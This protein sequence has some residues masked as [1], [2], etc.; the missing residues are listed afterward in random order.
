MAIQTIPGSAITAGTI[1][2]TQMS[3]T[4]QMGGPKISSIILTDSGYATITD[5]ALG[6]SGG[7][8]RILGTG[9]VTGCSVSINTV[10][11]TSV[12]FISS[13]EVRAQLP[14]MSAGTY[15]MYLSNSDGGV[16]IRVNAL[17]YSSTPS[18]TSTSPLTGGVVNTAISIQLG[19]TSD[20]TIS[21]TVQ[22]GSTLPTGLTLSSGG[23]LAGTVTGIALETTYNFTVVATDLESQISPKAFS[24]TIIVNDQYFKSTVLL[25]N[26]DVTPFTADAS[27]NKFE[28]SAVGTPSANVNNPLQPGYYSGSFNGSADYLTVPYGVWSAAATSWTIEGWFNFN[29]TSGTQGLF[30][31][32]AAF[33]VFYTGSSITISY[34]HTPSSP[35][36]ADNISAYTFTVRQWYHI[37]IVLTSGSL[38]VYV[39]GI[40]IGSPTTGIGT[41]AYW[42]GLS[43]AN[44]IMCIGANDTYPFGG[45]DTFFNGYISNVRLTNTAVYTGNFTPPTLSLTSTQSAGFLAATATPTVDILVVAGGGSGGGGGNQA[46][47]GGGGAGGVTPINSLSLSTGVSY[48]VTVGAGA[49]AVAEGSGTKGGNSAFGTTT[50]EGGGFGGGWSYVSSSGGSGGGAGYG[51][52]QTASVSNAVAPQLGNSGGDGISAGGYPGG[53]GGAGAAGGAALNSSTGGN[54][55]AGY[56][57]SISGVSTYYGGG[58]GAGVWTGTRGV[59]G[60]GGGGNGS[61]SA[62][63]DAALSNTGGGGGGSTANTARG[64]GGSG[65][66]GIVVLRYSS[67]YSLPSS[68]TGN[69]SVV[70][71]GGYRI[72]TWTTSGT[73]TFGDSNIAAITGTATSL[74][75]CQSNRFIDNSSTPQTITVSGTPS[76]SVAQPF[77]LPS[78]YTGYGSGLF[79]G[80]GD[81]LSV[82]DN[83]A[84]NIGTSDFQFSCWVYPTAFNSSNTLIGKGT[85]NLIVGFN[86]SGTLEIAQW[87]V[88]VRVTSST[89]LVLNQWSYVVASR[90]SSTS[91]IFLN[92]VAVGSGSDSSNYTSAIALQIGQDPNS[93][94]Q[95]ITGY[96]TDA[97]LVK[98]SGVT[99][100]ATPTAPLT[101]IANT[102]L[103]TLQTNQAQTN[104]Q[105]KDSGIN[106]F[107]ITRTGTVT[108]GTF[109]PFSQTGWS[110][111]FNGSGDTITAPS[112]SAFAFGTGDF[113]FETWAYS[114]DVTGSS[115]RGIFDNRTSS[116]STAG[117]LLR[118]NSGGF[119]VVINNSTLFSTS[120]KI[121]NTWQHLALVKASGVITLYVNGVSAGSASS[122]TSLTD[123][124]CRISGFVDTQASPYGYFG[125]ISNARVTKG[126]AVYTGNFTPPTAP[127]TATQAAGINIAAITGTATSLLTLQDNRFKDNALTPNTITVAGTPSVQAF[128]PFAPTAAYSLPVAAAGSAYFNGSSYIS[129]PDSTAFTMGSGDFTLE[130]WVY[131][132][133]SGVSRVI[134]GTCDAAGGAGSMSYVLGV[135]ASNNATLAI[136]YAGALYTSTNTVTVPTNQWVHIAG[137]RNGGGIYAYLN[138]VQS[139]SNTS[140]ASLAITD[141]TQTVAIGRNGAY[142]GEYLTGYISNARITKGTAVYTGN[143]QPPSA[144]LTAITGTSLLT[145]QDTTFIDNS[146][147]AAVITAGGTPVMHAFTPFASNWGGYF[148]G[149]SH[150]VGPTGNATL[151]AALDILGGDFTIEFWYNPTTTNANVCILTNFTASG[152]NGWQ[153][154]TRIGGFYLVTWTS[155]TSI[156]KLSTA[157][158]INAGIW[159]HVALVKLSGNLYFYVNGTEIGMYSGYTR[160]A[161]ANPGAGTGLGIGAYIQN[162][163]YPSYTSGYLSN[164]RV[165]KGTAVY[166]TNFQPPSA[167]LT[168]IT[169]T[170]LLTLQNNTFIDN[171]SNAA[172]ITPSGAPKTQLLQLPFTSSI[173]KVAAPWSIYQVTKVPA[174]W[175][176]SVTAPLATVGGS[177]YLNGTTDYLALPAG[178]AFAPGLG[179]FTVEGWYYATAT[180]GGQFIWAQTVSGSN[181]FVVSFDPAGS[182]FTF[183]GLGYPVYSPATV[184]PNC[185]NHFAVV[186]DATNMTVY[187]NGVAGSPIAFGT[188]YNFNNTTYVPVISGYTHSQT[189][190]MTGYLSNFR[191][192]K[193]TAVY[194]GNFTPPTAPP[195]P[196]QTPGLLG[197][198]VNAID[199]TNTSLLLLGSNAG[200]YDATA[201]N[202]IIT[203][204]NAQV[205]STQIKY[206][207]GAMYFDGTGDYLNIPN[208]QIVNFASGDYTVEAWVYPTVI[209]SDH[210]VFSFGVPGGHWSINIYQSNW[211][212]G[213]NLSIAGGS[214]SAALNTWTHVAVTRSSGTQ[215]FYLNGALI[216]SVADTNVITAN[217]TVYA[218]AYFGSGNYWNGYIDDLRATK[219]ARYTANFTPPTKA[220]IGQ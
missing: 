113:T 96:I 107:A 34:R 74:L 9:F 142:N 104:S 174:P 167:P 169:G 204:G 151:N 5:T 144:P 88:A 189:A 51:N 209:S 64:T 159:C 87:G 19:A 46:G 8:I 23:L 188:G 194:T 208:N 105:F 10:I 133:T 55:G 134:I 26:G 123:T 130:A 183:I 97:R 73:I 91:K 24:I 27:T 94:A 156:E 184:K 52:A 53:G 140:M 39:N 62:N 199:G 117:T 162:L 182:Q 36:W 138:G 192:V 31:I 30:T 102:S 70:V 154:G 16:A 165:V 32:F 219:Y 72:Y 37:A 68:T 61:A 44:T 22:A 214:A 77:T 187:A 178:S 25:L 218:G 166:T 129:V 143:F 121:T 114:L 13:T 108:Q 127:L 148:N 149:S 43:T 139:T 49:I 161:T 47:G 125:Y 180:S 38:R 115:L 65:G 158:G 33:Q 7:Y 122:A 110:G 79:N 58:G 14:S 50:A 128:S 29:S 136:G 90:V 80:T 131:L 95:K 170:S 54:G 76:I 146:T 168:A 1:T 84:L 173:T 3:N 147:N 172:T 21:Y 202:D 116:T 137:V 18:W 215:R 109:T 177:M 216:S 198:N 132:T 118:E 207:T 85:N 93:P 217:G 82:P 164:L 185:W 67:S 191:Y 99:T 17:T 75:T 106:N 152:A 40:A 86:S 179:P 220:M 63:G 197:T 186:R 157:I 124:N 89:N 213:Y 153:V 4:I 175:N 69:P 11:A 71:A 145:L 203:V 163:S 210:Y 48:T 42:D 15:I 135:N 190:M 205:S 101:A 171:S 193:G 196:T 176:I 195:Q 78:P 60:V 181:Y 56:S 103:L 81:Y 92:G 112:N 119:L 83:A 150:L 98:G 201:K 35:V 211:R 12:T 126:T 120:G 41:I 57:S 111:Y 206:G 45:A 212:V 141:S 28:I 200:I 160:T 20:S 100:V 66:S 2:A 6:L 59:G 155:N